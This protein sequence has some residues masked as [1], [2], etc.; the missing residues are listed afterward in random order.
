MALIT[1][2]RKTSFAIGAVFLLHFFA[3]ALSSSA[4]KKH[5]LILGG[6][7]FIGGVTTLSLLDNGHHV[8]LLNR[9]NPYYDSDKRIKP[10]AS[11]QINCDREKSLLLECKE[12]I[13]DET[14]Y[15]V[16]IDFTSFS[17]K[18]VSQIL[19]ALSGRI[20]LYVF[21]SSEA[22]YEVSAKNHTQPSKEGEATRPVSPNRRQE[23]QKA[24]PYGDQKLACEE[25]L[26]QQTKNGVPYLI[27]RLPIAIGPRDTT[28]R[29][30][31]YQLWIITHDVIRHPV[32]IPNGVR[33]DLFSLVHVDDVADVISRIV[34]MDTLSIE[35]KVVNLALKEHIT[36]PRV[37]RDIASYYG[38][39]NVQHE[40]DDK[41]TWY[42]YP[43]GTKGPLDI[44]RAQELLEWDPM[45]W[46]QAVEKTC[47]FYHNAM[48]KDDYLKEKEIVLADMLDNIV[49]DELYDAFLLKLKQQFGETVL[50]GVDLDVG[51]PE[52]ALEID[53]EPLQSSAGENDSERMAEE[54]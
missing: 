38:I 42:V 17:P 31:I 7:G 5:I 43:A 23:L 1:M 48:T 24:L 53:S 21:I 44:S 11:R 12:L 30:W 15:D 29:W 52:G 6:N 18:H 2:D 28:Y 32:H 16:V 45:P 41:S 10:H 33:S 54:L 20:G 35:N 46:K 14:F 26:M 49:P 4:P 27:L 40:G 13:D 50:A 3:G 34:A 47:E 19:D 39:D 22:V 9:G 37:I 51:I 25:L 36:L 8:T